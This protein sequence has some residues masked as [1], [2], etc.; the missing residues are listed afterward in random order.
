MVW[1]I[2]TFTQQNKQI[3]TKRALHLKQGKKMVPDLLLKINPLL[4]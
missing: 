1:L 2:S 4:A 3:L